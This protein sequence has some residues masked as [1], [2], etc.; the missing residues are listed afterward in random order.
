MNPGTLDKYYSEEWSSGTASLVAKIAG[1]MA[2]IAQDP[3]NKQSVM[4]GKFM[5]S[6]L[7]P[8]VFS[9]KQ[10][11]QM[12]GADGKPINP[13]GAPQTIDPSTMTDEQRQLLRETLADVLKGA[14][15]DTAAY[16]RSKIPEAE[17][18]MI[19]DGTNS[20]EYEESE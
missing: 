7:V 15:D 16:Q 9:E 2:I 3:N 19:E 4:A 11:I 18:T 13:N 20:A 6:R 12:L 17:Y 14:V 5:L 10:Q 1:N 8:E